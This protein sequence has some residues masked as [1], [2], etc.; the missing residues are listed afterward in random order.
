[1]GRPPSSDALSAN[2]SAHGLKQELED[3]ARMIGR[4]T[5]VATY[6]A[7]SA[8]I[9]LIHVTAISQLPSDSNTPSY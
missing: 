1:M 9:G 6:A 4:M 5:S 8:A 3:N 2:S 7:A